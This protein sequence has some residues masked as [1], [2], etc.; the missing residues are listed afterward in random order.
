MKL[1]TCQHEW[2]DVCTARYRCEPPIGYWFE[3]AHYP[4]S[5][6]LGGTETIRLWYPDHIVQGALQ[7]IEYNYPCIFTRNVDEPYILAEVYPEYVELYRQAESICKAHAGSIS[8]RKQ[9]EER[10][11][12]FKRDEEDVIKSCSNGGKAVQKMLGPLLGLTPQEVQIKNV[13]SAKSQKERKTGFFGMNPQERIEV[14]RE[15]ILKTNN[16]RWMDPDHPELGEH[17]SGTLTQM[18]KRRGFPHEKEN[19]IR[20]Y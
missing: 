17:S 8:G 4:L 19:R 13:K 14:S 5:K 15:A 6:K 1:I 10:L 11:G 20:V 7:T 9:W 16:Q 3:E 12:M 18:Q 2:V